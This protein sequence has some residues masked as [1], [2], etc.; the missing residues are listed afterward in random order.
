MFKS[1]TKTEIY[2]PNLVGFNK[3]ISVISYKS[4]QILPSGQAV[5]N[6]ALK[7]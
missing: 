5:F 4:R 1:P 6:I 3:N 7:H 2:R